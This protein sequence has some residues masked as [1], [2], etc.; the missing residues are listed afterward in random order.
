A[1]GATAYVHADVQN[2]TGAPATQS[3]RLTWTTLDPGIATVAPGQ[4]LTDSSVAIQSVANGRARVVV[5]ANGLQP[6]TVIVGVKQ[7][8]ASVTL[9]DPAGSGGNAYL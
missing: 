3:V 6:D 4:S 1:L 2:D 8:A 7:R 5:S 9:T